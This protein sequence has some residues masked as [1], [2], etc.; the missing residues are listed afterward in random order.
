MCFVGYFYPPIE[1]GG[2]KMIDVLTAQVEQTTENQ[3]NQYN[4]WFFF[5][6]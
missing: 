4:Q 3:F 5:N 6:H 1:I 2:F